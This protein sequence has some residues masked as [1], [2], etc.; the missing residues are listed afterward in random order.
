MPPIASFGFESKLT[1]CWFNSKTRWVM[2]FILVAALVSAEWVVAGWLQRDVSGRSSLQVHDGEKLSASVVIPEDRYLTVFDG[3]GTEV[4]LRGMTLE[5]ATRDSLVEDNPLSEKVDNASYQLLPDSDLKHF[6]ETA[7]ADQ[8]CHVSIDLK[9]AEVD[10]KVKVE[11]SRNQ[12]AGSVRMGVAGSEIRTQIRFAPQCVRKLDLGPS[13]WI[14]FEGPEAHEYL[15]DSESLVDVE[16]S[17]GESGSYSIPVS[18]IEIIPSEGEQGPLLTVWCNPPAELTLSSPA[19][20]VGVLSFELLG[21]A[22]MRGRR[23]LLA[24]LWRRPSVMGIVSVV[25]AS[26]AVLFCGL[27]RLRMRIFIS[28][29]RDDSE[30]VANQIYSGLRR[31]LGKR[32]VFIDEGLRVGDKWLEQIKEQIAT[33]DAFLVVIGKRWLEMKD[34]AGQRRL[35]SDKD[36]VR[37]EIETALEHQVPIVPVLVDGA[38][39]PSKE[40]LPTSLGGLPDW[41]AVVVHARFREFE[42][43]IRRL[44]AAI[45]QL[46]R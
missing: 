44:L 38:G 2:W 7:Q 12:R 37:V 30:R 14:I 40:E 23:G 25:T 17:E 43:D 26:L 6:V 45:F 33:R 41:Q 3:S 39:M 5:K 35:D 13:W 24:W 32:N 15:T 42:Q 11:L 27:I 46:K 18:E 22:E 19:E 16:V 10:G 1:S 31:R 36:V 4:A 21:E 9:L 29:R 28:Y 20:E 8:I 34:D